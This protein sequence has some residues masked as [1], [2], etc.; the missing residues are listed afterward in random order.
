MA[1]VLNR[2]VVK[3][4]NVVV[5]ANYDS[6]PPRYWVRV[7]PKGF[8]ARER[9]T[10]LT[11]KLLPGKTPDAFHIGMNETSIELTV[12]YRGGEQQKIHI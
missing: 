2:G 11:S 4:T 5:Y 10:D 7:K 3:S 6:S 1:V 8:L 9:K 12:I